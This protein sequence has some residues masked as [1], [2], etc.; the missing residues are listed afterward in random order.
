MLGSHP[1]DTPT[2]QIESSPKTSPKFW[3]FEHVYQVQRKKSQQ[4]SGFTA[5]LHWP[6]KQSCRILRLK[7]QLKYYTLYNKNTELFIEGILQKGF[8]EKVVPVW[9]R[10]EKKQ[11]GPNLGQM[12]QVWAANL[13]RFTLVHQ[14]TQHHSCS[15]LIKAYAR[16]KSQVLSSPKFGHFPLC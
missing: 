16:R 6:W 11:I 13:G 4:L 10:Q 7:K 12:S 14:W 2:A 15:I 3:L 8:F 1:T 5:A 9:K